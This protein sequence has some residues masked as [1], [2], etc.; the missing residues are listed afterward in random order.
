MKK[1]LLIL[2]LTLAGLSLTAGPLHTTA[3][4]PEPVYILAMEYVNQRTVLTDVPIQD[5]ATVFTV[6]Q[7]A[8]VPGYVASV[9]INELQHFYRPI[10]YEYVATEFTVIKVTGFSTYELHCNKVQIV[11][12]H[13]ESCF[14]FK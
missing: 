13:L 1:F 2:G 4:V 11:P 7:V 3:P 12:W 8:P 9:C 5:K 10:V 6:L 14:L